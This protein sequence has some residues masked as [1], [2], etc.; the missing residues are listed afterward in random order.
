MLVQS[1]DPFFLRLDVKLKR[2]EAEILKGERNLRSLGSVPE[3][4]MEDLADMRSGLLSLRIHNIYNGMEQVWEDIALRIDGE[5]PD[6]E[7]HMPSFS[8]R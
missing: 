4:P 2:I 7:G 3:L 5:K 6:G 8:S 1:E